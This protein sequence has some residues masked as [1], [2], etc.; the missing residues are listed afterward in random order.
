MALDRTAV[1]LNIVSPIAEAIPGFGTPVKAA[2]DATA[3][4][5]KYAGVRSCKQSWLQ[6][7]MLD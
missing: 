2:F 6:C 4:I 5:L 1:F 3:K 7:Y